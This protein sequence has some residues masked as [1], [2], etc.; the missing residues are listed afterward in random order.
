MRLFR[1]S[2]ILRKG[3]RDRKHGGGD[4]LILSDSPETA[5]K[6][7]R[8]HLEDY[9]PPLHVGS[10]T[11]MTFGLPISWTHYLLDPREVE[12]RI[13]RDP[14]FPAEPIEADGLTEATRDPDF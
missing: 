5:R 11:E 12:V 9:D 4:Y 1:V 3:R 14:E 10:P 2:V 6:A 8:D 7:I 13:K